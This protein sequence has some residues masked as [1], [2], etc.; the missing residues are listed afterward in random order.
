VGAGIREVFAF[1]VLLA[2]LLVRPT[3]L[4]GLP[5]KKRV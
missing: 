2:V 4:F 3:G 1:V 5:D